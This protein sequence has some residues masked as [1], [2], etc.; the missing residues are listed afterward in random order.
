ML[1]GTEILVGSLFILALVVMSII[2]AAFTNENKLAVR[3]L[4]D[5]TNSKAVPSLAALLE[6]RAEVLTSVHIII[7]LLLVSGAVLL[8]SVF[9]RRE[10]RYIGGAL[11]TVVVMM[12]FILVFRH[13]IPRIVAMRSPE[14]VLLRL[15]PVFKTAHFMLRPL[16]RLLMSALNYFHKWDEEM[17]PAKEEET[18]EEEIQ[19]FIDAGQEE[20]IL[21][22]D[23]GEM[24][25]SIVHFGDKAAR[26]VMTPRTQIVAIDINAPVDKLLQLIV[27]TRHARIPV[28]RDDLDNMEGVVHERDLLRVLQKG[29]RMETFKSLVKPVH[30][31][32]E[33][34]PVDDLLQ[35]M[36]EK[37]DQIVLVVD[38]YG[39]V[40]GLITMEDLIEEIVGEIHDESEA[41]GEKVIEESQ[42]V[43]LVPGSLELGLLEETLG[44]PLV[45]ETACT[46]VAGAVVELFGRLPSPGEKIEHGGVEIEI[47]DADRRRVQ[48]L[49]LKTLAPKR[50]TS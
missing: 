11:G 32:P 7:Q 9:D 3:R 12:V 37:G 35:E 43:Y 22:H 34:K 47:L 10:I 14:I 16:S 44:S 19:A 15:F 39:G 46:T 20:G 40:S 38:E 13:L 18:S 36:K 2:D 45:A 23:E 50:M 26:E 1:S 42:G 31:V 5:R 48:R 25:Q 21:E 30:F 17:E 6:T 28:Y 24:I 4:A 49:R 27:G 29:E 8:Y 41:A 33:T